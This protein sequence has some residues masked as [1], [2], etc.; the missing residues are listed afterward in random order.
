[1][2]LVLAET[3]EAAREGARLVAVHY[4]EEPHEADLDGDSEPYAPE[5]V[6]AGHETDSDDG[7]VDAA[8]A[9]AAGRGRRGTYSTPHEYNS[10]M[11]P[12]AASPR[13]DGATL[14]LW[15][16]TQAVHAVAATLAP[17]LGLEHDPVRVRAPYVGGGFGSKGLPHAPEVAA[18]LAA[19]AARRAAR[20]GWP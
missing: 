3:S 2:A 11:E 13:W 10:P 1:M 6:N 14:T 15:D 8:L 5:S 9:A 20:S 17:M 16:S 4:D 18:A 7:D 19:M 12:H